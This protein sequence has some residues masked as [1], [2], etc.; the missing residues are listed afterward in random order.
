MK[1]KIICLLPAVMF[2]ST[3]F[4]GTPKYV[5]KKF[6]DNLLSGKIE[7]AKKYA[8]D[9][10]GKLLDLAVL[11][12]ELPESEGEEFIFV[13][14]IIESDHALVKF[15]LDK[16]G[17]VNE[18]N[19]VMV[20]GRWKADLSLTF[21]DAESQNNEN[22][23]IN[24]LRILDSSKEMWWL[25]TDAEIGDVPTIDDLNKYLRSKP[26]CPSGGDYSLNELGAN[27][28][29]SIDGHALPY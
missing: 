26:I 1:S 13:D 15:K 16:D 4:I 10:T 12:D 9:S 29:C 25:D 3:G 18:L 5:A 17:E 24:N 8:T 21:S 23:C 27:P 2:I 11:I 20:D 28:E 19:M 7:E 6:M 22:N 14:E